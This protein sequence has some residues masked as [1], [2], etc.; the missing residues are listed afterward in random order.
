MLPLIET[1]KAENGLL[2]YPS[3]HNQRMNSSA[4]KL[5][6]KEFKWDVDQILKKQLPQSK[7]T[8]RCRITYTDTILSTEIKPYTRTQIRSL[9]IIHANDID[10]EYKWAQR[11]H[12]ES[13]FSKRDSCDDILIIKNDRICDSSIAN[14]VFFDG[15]KYFTPLHPLL[16]GCCRERLLTEKRIFLKDIHLADL[17]HFQSF[18]LINALRDL[19][20]NDFHLIENII[21]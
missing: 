6:N 16:K 7:N 14:I 5:Y 11:S 1:I 12:I 4:G 21:H 9:K 10:Y 2:M 13:L 18:T 19:D 20:L 3:Y 15:K 8:Y 17:E